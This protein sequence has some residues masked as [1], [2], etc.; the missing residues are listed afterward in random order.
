MFQFQSKQIFKWKMSVG[1]VHSIFIFKSKQTRYNVLVATEPWTL[2]HCLSKQGWLAR[3]EFVDWCASYRNG[4]VKCWEMWHIPSLV[5]CIS[6]GCQ[7]Q[8]AEAWLLAATTEW[9]ISHIHTYVCMHMCAYAY[10]FTPYAHMKTNTHTY[11]HV[12]PHANTYLIC[13]LTF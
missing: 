3:P 13:T 10:S 4:Y 6:Q 8:S 11:K 9:N 12:L 7:C 2:S 5:Q 1:N